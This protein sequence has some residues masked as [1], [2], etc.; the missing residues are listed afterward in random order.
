MMV[1]MMLSGVLAWGEPDPND[2]M[3]TWQEPMARTA[4]V[5]GKAKLK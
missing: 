2:T 5:C 1:V 4:L 3:I